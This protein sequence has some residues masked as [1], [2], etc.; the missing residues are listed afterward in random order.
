MAG[1]ALA[2]GDTR[3]RAGLHGNL[4]LRAG[5]PRCVRRVPAVLPDELRCSP[6]KH[7]SPTGSKPR[8]RIPVRLR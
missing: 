2:G 8:S 7:A 1:A 3:V 6:V 5:R 4:L